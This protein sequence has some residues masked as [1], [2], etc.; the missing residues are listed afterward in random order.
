VQKP[1]EREQ[2]EQAAAELNARNRVLAGQRQRELEIMS[3]MSASTACIETYL[4]GGDP[5]MDPARLAAR[6]ALRAIH[7]DPSVA[8]VLEALTTRLTGAWGHLREGQWA[9]VVLW[10]WPGLPR[11]ALDRPSDDPLRADMRE[12]LPALAHSEGW[13]R[14]RQVIVP[15]A[16]WNLPWATL[17]VVAGHLPPSPASGDCQ[18]GPASTGRL[19]TKRGS[20]GHLVETS[21]PS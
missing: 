14:A 11:L 4:A 16:G 9:P 17:A 1:A 2:R 5:S 18:H 6:L 3:S 13:R 8:E 20:G 21:R 12:A 7:T 19:T 15:G 10:H